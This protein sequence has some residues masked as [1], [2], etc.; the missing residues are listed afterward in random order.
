MAVLVTAIHAATPSE[1]LPEEERILNV[2][3]APRLR[4]GVDARD[5]HGHDGAVNLSSKP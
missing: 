4:P 1:I 3:S 2:L 5:K